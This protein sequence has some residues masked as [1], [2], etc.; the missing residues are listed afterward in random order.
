MLPEMAQQVVV[1]VTQSQWSEA[2]ANEME[3]V[4]GEHYYFDYHDPGEEHSTDF[5]YTDIVRK[6]GGDY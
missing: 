5:E 2:V 4:A 3:H 1:M 6:S